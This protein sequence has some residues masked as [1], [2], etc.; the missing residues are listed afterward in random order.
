MHLTT[1]WRE[2]LGR[3][4]VVVAPGLHDSVEFFE[5][6]VHGR[7]FCACSALFAKRKRYG[8]ILVFG[9]PQYFKGS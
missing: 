7:F 9:T 1:R 3:H 6:H 4:V 8:I 2:P 5:R